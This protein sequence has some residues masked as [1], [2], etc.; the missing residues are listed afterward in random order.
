MK[1]YLLFALA[2]GLCLP[3]WSQLAV[4]ADNNKHLCQDEDIVYFG[5]RPTT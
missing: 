4:D 2:C 5:G 3:L 1:K